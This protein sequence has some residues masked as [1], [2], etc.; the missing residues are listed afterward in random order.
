MIEFRRSSKS[1]R[2]ADCKGIL[3][4]NAYL[5]T[6]IS[7]SMRS[8]MS[9]TVLRQVESHSITLSMCTIFHLERRLTTTECVN[10]SPTPE[11]AI[12]LTDSTEDPNTTKTIMKPRSLGT[13]KCVLT[14]SAK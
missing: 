9:Y 2:A 7:D 4:Y 12:P 11:S 5:E 6:S 1:T 13:R 8:Q 3:N 14:Y 10:I